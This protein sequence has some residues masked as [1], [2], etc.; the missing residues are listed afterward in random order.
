MY[1]R[2]STIVAHPSAI[3]EGIAFVRDE[4]WPA[5]QSMDGCIGLSMVADRGSGQ[6][7]VTSSWHDLESLR[8]SAEHVM[9]MRERAVQMMDAMT[10]TVQ[11]WEIVS[12]HRDHHSEPG[13][14]VRAAW[15]RVAPKQ[16][17]PA[18]DFYKYVLLPEIEQMDGF[19][20]A[21]L[22]VDRAAGRGVTSVAYDSRESLEASRDKADYLR[23]TSTNEAHVEFLDV[24]EFELVFA[25]LDVPEL[26]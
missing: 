15:S 19:V 20:S 18:I 12:M 24:S 6:G 22:L 8:A 23:G 4:V 5:M 11:E 9:P 16:V 26:V 25:H 7:I 2:S 13:T 3:D 1:A 17:G 14:W 10:P 21:S